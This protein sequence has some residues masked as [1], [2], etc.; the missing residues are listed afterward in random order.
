MLSV[1][2]L[3]K[4]YKPK[5][6]APVTALD[7]VSLDF[8]E[9]GMIFL[10]GKSGSGKSTLLNLLGGLDGYTSGEIIIKGKSSKDFKT[11]DFDSYRN[12]FI[13]FIFQEFNLIED[14]GV[15]KNI[16]LALEL[17]R[18]RADRDAV[19]SVM[20]AV[21][22]DRS[23]FDR[24]TGE[25]SGG[26]RQRVAIARALVKDPD[27]LMADEPTGSLDSKTGAQVFDTLKKLSGDKLVI[28]VSHD[29]E[30]AEIY[31]DRVI[32]LAD[33]KIIDD[34]TKE[35]SGFKPTNENNILRKKYT[36]ED[37]KL[38]RSSLPFK[39][40]FKLGLSG[41]K[42]KKLRL[43]FTI[44]LSFFAF[45]LFGLSATGAAYDMN[46]SNFG[47]I[48]ANNQK[49]VLTVS[50]RGFE[51]GGAYSSEG[52][53]VMP[54]QIAEIERITGNKVLNTY[55]DRIGIADGIS[56]YANFATYPEDPY[57]FAGYLSNLLETPD[58][59]SAG[60]ISAAEGS[61]LPAEG[62]ILKSPLR[63]GRLTVL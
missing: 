48:K 31:G 62:N 35:G 34:R 7:N 54:E 52:M 15:G 20:E 29:R 33:G 32:E 11:V 16:G 4:I 60:L 51:E 49:T 61:R 19:Y 13:G 40:S 36:A 44:I 39:D 18:K 12:T 30:N 8:P 42:I 5:K 22:L 46:K 41:L 56:L 58:E 14:Y 3:T 59:A 2:N 55:K 37:F 53:G 27:I 45:T 50:V 17:Q 1:K 26:Q 23:L 57:Y 38:I 47:T 10:L 6:G 63:T 21:E 24:K 25:L 28:V 43:A 9:K